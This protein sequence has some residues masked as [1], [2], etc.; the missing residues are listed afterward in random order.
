MHENR[1]MMPHSTIQTTPS[2]QN[3]AL[4]AY[5]ADLELEVDRL[6]NTASSSSRK[7]DK[8]L[9]KLSPLAPIRWPR[10]PNRW[11]R[12]N[13]L[14]AIWRTARLARTAR[15]PSRPRSGRCHCTSAPDRASLPLAAAV[16]PA[17]RPPSARARCG[18]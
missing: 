9:S 12:S 7:P 8:L 14:R 16:A 1:A 13:I 15:L 17:A 11:R 4:L 18:L 6:G 10:H 5:V 3:H 2:A